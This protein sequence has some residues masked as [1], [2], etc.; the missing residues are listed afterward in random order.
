VPSVVRLVTLTIRPHPVCEHSWQ[1]R[2]NDLHCG[3]H[4]H[5]VGVEEMVK[6]DRPD[7]GEPRKADI[8]DHRIDLPARDDLSQQFGWWRPGRRGPLMELAREVVR[9]GSRK[10]DRYVSSRGQSIRDG[11]PDCLWTLR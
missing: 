2:L 1:G 9:P 11:S 4:V 6:L 3:A 10:A 7:S 5:V 8:V